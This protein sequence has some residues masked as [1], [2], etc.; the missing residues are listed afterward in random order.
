MT[1]LPPNMEAQTPAVEATTLLEALP[2]IR[3][4]AGKVIVIKYGGNIL[5][6][7]NDEEALALFAHDIVLIQ[8]VGMHPVVVHGGGP[9][10]SETMDRLGKQPE[11]RDGLRVTDAETVDIVRSVLIDQVNPQIVA[12]MNVHGSLAVGVSGEDSDLIQ[13][14]MRDP[15]LGYVGDVAGVDPQVLKDLLARD[16]IPVVAPIGV[17]K[18]GQAYNINADTAAGAIAESLGAE[19]LIYLTDVDGLRREASNPESLIRQTTVDELD[20]MIA[21]GSISDG[22]IP[23]ALSCAKAL[24]GGVRRAHILDGRIAHVLLLELFTDEGIGTMVQQ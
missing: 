9:Q 5:S 15:A 7:A 21:D 4:F 13:A 3:R 14:S 11:F 16:L 20:A 19:K 24:R 23:K 10:I 22:M 18:T 12:A 17:D 6:G 1:N 8:Q 2:Y